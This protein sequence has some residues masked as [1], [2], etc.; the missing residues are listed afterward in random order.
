M[1]FQQF[2]GKLLRMG[3]TAWL[4]GA[5]KTLE[6]HNCVHR[7]RHLP[8]S[9]QP[10]F[11]QSRMKQDS[12]QEFVRGSTLQFQGLRH[13]SHQLGPLVNEAGVNLHQVGT[14]GH[15]G[16]CVGPAHDPAHAD[17]REL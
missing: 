13:F 12:K 9:V 7:Y 8:G 17:D 3:W 1:A 14:C 2:S 5:N 16:L 4:W 10:L 6:T 11:L 15:F